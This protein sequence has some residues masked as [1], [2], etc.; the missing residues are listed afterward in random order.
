MALIKTRIVMNKEK[1]NINMNI[2][3]DFYRPF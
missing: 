2:N 3:S 1:I